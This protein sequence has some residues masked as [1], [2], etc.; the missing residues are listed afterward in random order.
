MN[1]FVRSLSTVIVG[2]AAF[3]SAA[4][5][6]I[7]PEG[8][9]FSDPSARVW[10]DGRIYIYG[11]RDEGTTYWCSA[12]NDVLWSDDLRQWQI[13]PNVFCSRGEHDG[14]AATDAPL[15][16]SDAIYINHRYYLFYC[17]P[18][19]KHSEG[20]AESISPTGPFV[21][22]RQIEGPTQID[23]SVLIDDDG[24]IYY[25]WGQNSLKCAQMKPDM[26][27]LDMTTYR[28][29][30]LTEKQHHFH[31]GAQAFKRNGIY[32][33]SFTDNSRGRPTCI[34]YA[35]ANSPFG[36][37]TYRGVIIDNAGCDPC[38]WNNH[39]SVVEI[40]GQWYVFY[41]RSTNG[42]KVFRKA[43]IE[44][45]V[46]NEQG[47]IAEV[48]MT[49]Q[50]VGPML[51]PFMTTETRIASKL[52]GNV[53]V[54]TLPGGKELL[55]G[56]HNGDAAVFRYFDF[57][58]QPSK[59]QLTVTPHG[60]GGINI[61]TDKE[62]LHRLCQVNIH[63]NGGGVGMKVTATIDANIIVKGRIPLY[64]D[65]FGDNGGTLFDIDSFI[66]D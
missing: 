50:G 58:H 18:D 12:N 61:Y 32:Y 11:S 21:N 7:T 48:E 41:H 39:G 53:R 66:F 10:E 25:F 30:I 3:S 60:G 43:C 27:G 59:L 6:P 49:S 38:N 13:V 56:I 31:E 5:N 17:T 51:N 19:R 63:R 22:A 20:V 40:G 1:R 54:T 42:Q 8:R 23:P 26:S 24:T 64:F 65:F 16:A 34:G 52:K 2:I 15:F 4:Q 33:L 62:R 45:I 46:F 29:N 28:E 44:P 55:T 47:L 57:T 37:Y 9:F 14:V 35:T 36:P